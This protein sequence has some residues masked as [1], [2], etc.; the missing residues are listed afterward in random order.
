[1]TTESAVASDATEDAA[2]VSPQDSST[3]VV[4]GKQ[5][6]TPAKRWAL[7]CE[8]VYSRAQK[9][10]FVGGDPL[11]DLADAEQEIDA[12]YETDFNWLFSL[13]ST[14]EITEQLKPLTV[15]KG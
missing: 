12:A 11:Q 2:E 6:V 7:I 14:A 5:R 4:D 15:I 8:N 13:T 10:G 3:H 1:M 9:R